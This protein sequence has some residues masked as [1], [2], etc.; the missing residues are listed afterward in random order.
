MEG[1]DF[2]RVMVVGPTEAGKS[3][4]CNFIQRDLTNSILIQIF[5]QEKILNMNLEIQ[6]KVLILQKMILI[7][8][9]YY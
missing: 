5:L 8:Y 9:H 2:Y 6:L 4:F 1:K 7:I 3:Q